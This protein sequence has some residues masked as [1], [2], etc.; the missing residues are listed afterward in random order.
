MQSCRSTSPPPC[1]R[2]YLLCRAVTN[3][4][5]AEGPR[6]ELCSSDVE[7]AAAFSLEGVQHQIVEPRNDADFFAAVDAR[8]SESN[9]WDRAMARSQGLFIVEQAGSDTLNRGYLVHQTTP[10]SR[11]F[12]FSG[13]PNY[14]S[15]EKKHDCPHAP[16]RKS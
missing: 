13:V 4:L 11:Q 14:Q 1:H 9:D 3:S 16:E 6:R 7:A 12:A 5:L 15:T 8:E 2:L 10:S